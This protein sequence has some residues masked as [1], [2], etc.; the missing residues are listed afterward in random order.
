MGGDK[1]KYCRT[2]ES[3]QLISAEKG[4]NG[5]TVILEQLRE[6]FLWEQ[7]SQAGKMN[8]WKYM[9]KFDN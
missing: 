8:W 3:S 1:E 9:A 2:V 7:L 6:H 4:L 5:L